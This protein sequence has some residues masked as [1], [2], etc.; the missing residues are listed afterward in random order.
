MEKKEKDSSLIYE[1]KN[2]W[3]ETPK[4]EQKAAMDYATGFKSFLDAAKTERESVKWIVEELQKTSLWNW[5]VVKDPKRF[6]ASS[7]AKRWLLL[8]SVPSPW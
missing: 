1:R 7:E 3:K 5:A 4:A 2:F 8:Y 6:M